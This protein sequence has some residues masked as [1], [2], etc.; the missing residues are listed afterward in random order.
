M[1]GMAWRGIHINYF[2]RFYLEG[3]RINYFPRVTVISIKIKH[4]STSGCV[5]LGGVAHIVPKAYIVNARN[6]LLFKFAPWATRD[7]PL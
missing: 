1:N 4:L 3:Q 6:V 2:T 7:R 5:R